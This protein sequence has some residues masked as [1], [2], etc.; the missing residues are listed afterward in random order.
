MS[1]L[2]PH[3]LRFASLTA[4]LALL[5][6]APTQAVPDTQLQQDIKDIE[7]LSALGDGAQS[8]D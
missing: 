8:L 4:V 3:R 7:G 6:A 2:M 5:V 1:L